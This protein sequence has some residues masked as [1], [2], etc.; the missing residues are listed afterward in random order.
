[1]QRSAYKRIGEITLYTLNILGILISGELCSYFYEMKRM[2][3]VEE[4]GIAIARNII[5]MKNTYENV[6]NLFIACLAAISVVFLFLIYKL[7]R[8]MGEERSVDI[9]V[10]YVLGYKK[11]SVLMSE[12][13]YELSGVMTAMVL[14]VVCMASILKLV[15]GMGTVEAIVRSA[16]MPIYSADVVLALAAVIIAVSVVNTAARVMRSYGKKSRL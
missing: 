16:G 9:S 13:K 7:L 10:M 11:R 8:H 12:L 5:A 4:I 3:K 6:V 2:G 15:S 1:M 14:A